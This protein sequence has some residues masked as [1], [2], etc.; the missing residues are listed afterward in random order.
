V[1]PETTRSSTASLII[2]NESRNQETSR[3]HGGITS[4]NMRPGFRRLTSRLLA[5]GALVGLFAV[6][7]VV[8]SASAQDDVPQGFANAVAQRIN[9]LAGRQYA[10]QGPISFVHLDL[11]IGDFATGTDG[12]YVVDPSTGKAWD[13]VATLLQRASGEA[14]WLGGVHTV[15]QQEQ[16]ISE[17]FGLLTWRAGF[18]EEPET[19]LQAAE[20]GMA[21]SSTEPY[22]NPAFTYS[23][24]PINLAEGWTHQA[25]G[26][27][28]ATINRL[29]SGMWASGRRSATE[30]RAHYVPKACP[31]AIAV[32]A[33]EL[34]R[35]VPPSGIGPSPPC[36]NSY[37]VNVPSAPVSSGNG[38][39]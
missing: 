32:G 34:L 17:V 30:P 29:V 25:G 10:L 2:A 3:R 33:D 39:R 9:L 36:A 28:P 8:R 38:V 26:R 19:P 6:T 1:T 20:Y 7:P 18:I 37:L 13:G 15:A 24:G 12:T 5:A 23:N 35:L 14:S 11:E 21:P 22:P 16:Q 31:R 4:P 27:Q